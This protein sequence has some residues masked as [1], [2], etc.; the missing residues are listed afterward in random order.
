[1]KSVN[2]KGS[3]RPKI[4]KGSFSIKGSVQLEGAAESRSGLNLKAYAFSPVGELLGSGDIDTKGNF[5]L[6]LNRKEVAG[7]VQLL[8]GPASDPNLIRSSSAHKTTV[9]AEDWSGQEGKYV[10]S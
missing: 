8:V 5:S 9:S 2:P 4:L 1:M 7:A 6:T 10:F 3:A